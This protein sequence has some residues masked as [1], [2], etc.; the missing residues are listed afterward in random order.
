MDQ[1][2]NN[3]KLK[4]LVFCDYYLPGF[5]AGG[6]IRSISNIIVNLHE[7]FDFHI[8]TSDRDFLMEGPYSD[9]QLGHWKAYELD[10][11]LYVP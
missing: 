11:R 9:I 10:S 5:K 4:I 6:P 2:S 1:S 7:E 3:T 8:Y